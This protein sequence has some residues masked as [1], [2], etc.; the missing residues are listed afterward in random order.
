MIIGR[1]EYIPIKYAH[2]LTY[3]EPSI[4]SRYIQRVDHLA[5]SYIIYIHDGCWLLNFQPACIAPQAAARHML[6]YRPCDIAGLF[7]YLYTQGD[8][9]SIA[10]KP[11]RR[12]CVARAFVDVRDLARM[13]A[14][15]GSGGVFSSSSSS[16][17]RS[18]TAATATV[19][20]TSQTSSSSS[21]FVKQHTPSSSSIGSNSS[22]SSTASSSA[23]APSPACC[24][25][26]GREAMPAAAPKR[27]RPASSAA[28][29]ASSWRR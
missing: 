18:R 5:A 3:R 16:S 23:A 4:S 17:N 24:A 2:L 14:R 6:I 28:A 26:D 10:A 1:H 22:A 9:T 25:R 27:M 19:S 21:R 13:S 29:S 11:Q 8:V 15:N 7:I 20:P 12:H